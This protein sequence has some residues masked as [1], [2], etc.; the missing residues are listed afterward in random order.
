M[1]SLFHYFHSDS[2]TGLYWFK[3]SAGRSSLFHGFGHWH[4]FTHQTLFH[5]DSRT[6]LYWFKHSA[7]RSSLFHGFEHCFTLIH[8][9][10]CTDSGIQQA[11]VH[12][13][14]F[15]TLFHPDSRTNLFRVHCFTVLD[16]VSHW[17]MHQFV[18]IQAFSRQGFTVSRFWTLFHTDSRTGLYR[19]WFRHGKASLFHCFGHC[20]TLIHTYG[21]SFTDSSTVSYWFRTDYSY[22]C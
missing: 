1:G 16:N 4:W 15:W 22:A 18:L 10:I 19:Y 21:F 13:S 8:A 9:P 12:C 6:G 17:F 20:L 5:T 2:R 7:G 3:H 14:R 11:G